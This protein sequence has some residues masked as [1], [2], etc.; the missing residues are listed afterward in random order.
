MNFIDFHADTLY[1][2]FYRP[3]GEAGDLQRN[4]C[5]VDLERLASS[6]YAAQVF[7][8][9]LDIEKPP[10]TDSCYGDVLGMADLFTQQVQ[11]YRDQV[12]FAG[13]YN[14]YRDNLSH[15]FISGFLSLEEGGVLEGQITRLDSLY[16]KGVRIMNLTWN[17]ENCLGY[18]HRPPEFQ[19]KG[20]K[21]FGI[22]VV[23]R[24]DELGIIVDVSHLS[25]QGF[26]DVVRYGTRPF[27]ATHSNARA[28]RKVSRNLTDHMIRA[29]ADCG[30]IVGLNL[31]PAFLAE[32]PSHNVDAILQH[33]KHMINQGGR[34]S[35]GL[36]TDFDGM[37]L[38][39]TIK[40]A[41]NM[42]YLVQAMEQAGFSS[43]Q[44]E[45]VCYRNAEQFFQRYWSES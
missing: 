34:Q 26:W 39:P 13:N 38:P 40:D 4:S 37:D 25:D 44:I 35:V 19:K 45:D 3:Q 9:F 30:G 41:S 8:C 32:P 14:Q 31:Y 24:M 1:R 29:V 16:K 7:A 6:G 43:G 27:L 18:P 17:H 33:L 22:D 12:R 21:P 36:G 5:Q 23:R 10:Q 2:L 28:L 20:L 11:K 42:P 15:G